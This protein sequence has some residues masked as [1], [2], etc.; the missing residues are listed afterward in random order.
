MRLKDKVRI[1]S[2]DSSAYIDFENHK[3]YFNINEREIKLNSNAINI[4]KCLCF[5]YNVNDG[6]VQNYKI[7]KFINGYDFD[8]SKDMNMQPIT[9]AVSELRKKIT[10]D[11][12]QYSEEYIISPRQGVF[13]IILPESPFEI[14]DNPKLEN[15]ELSENSQ[16]TYKCTNPDLKSD[17]QKTFYLLLQDIYENLTTYRGFDI[18]TIFF[19]KD[20]LCLIDNEIK[21]MRKIFRKIMYYSDETIYLNQKHIC[22]L[23]IIIGQYRKYVDLL[24]LYKRSFLNLKD[25]LTI[26]YSQ[27]FTE[28]ELN[29][30]SLERQQCNI[31]LEEYA[32]LS[33]NEF[34]SLLKLIIIVLKNS[35]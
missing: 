24:K 21:N 23:R 17:I 31:C 7:F 26:Q 32:R 4:L 29:T 14:I 25:F 28:N 33:E 34:N 19:D 27:L 16:S 11:G 30:L 22:S 8:K 20:P 1:G 3:Y 15:I 10:K 35:R 6:N 9:K 18:K 13:K 12:T 5:A 2:S